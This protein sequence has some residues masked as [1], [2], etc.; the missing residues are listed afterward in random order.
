MQSKVIIAHRG[1]IN[2][3]KKEDENQP[4]AIDR[5]I[6]LGLDVE[7]DVWGMN[8]MLY[9]GHDEPSLQID[10]NFLLDRA[11]WLWVHAK[12]SEGLAKLNNYPLNY[13][14]HDKDS[15]T[16]TAQGYIW[17]RPNNYI[18][19]QKEI[20]V[21]PEKVYGDEEYKDSELNREDFHGI[22]TDF[23]LDFSEIFNNPK[24]RPE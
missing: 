15:H 12:N 3:V 24:V 6:S 4:F 20:L 1:N 8:G 2:G 11:T 22:C 7:I 10:V 19:C 13:F 21:L 17:S 9:L 16:F 23:A 18:F 5:A 14:F